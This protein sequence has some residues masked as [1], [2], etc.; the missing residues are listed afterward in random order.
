MNSRTIL[1][2]T[3]AVLAAAA[4]LM[5]AMPLSADDVKGLDEKAIRELK[6]SFELT[7]ANMALINAVS[8]NDLQ[9]LT[10][11]IRHPVSDP[12]RTVENFEHP[13]LDQGGQAELPADLVDNLFFFQFFKHAVILRV[14]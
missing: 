4:V 12:G 1:K 14:A 7:P 2:M 13:L 11:R 10:F 6:G 3:L 5:S 9:D 8:N